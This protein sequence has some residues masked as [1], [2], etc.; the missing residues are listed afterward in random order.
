MIPA[1]VIAAGRS[2]RMGQPKALLTL[3]PDRATFVE[4]L[5]RSL[6]AGGV[7]DVLVVVRPD[8]DALA[9]EIERL[10]ASGCAVRAAANADSDRGQLS[11][12]VV[13]LNAVDRPGVHAIMLAPVDSPLVRSATVRTLIDAFAS[14]PAPIVRATHGGRH[15]HPVI[16]SRVVFDALRH[17]DP[18]IGARAVVRAHAHDAID[19]DV[20]DP[21]VL[22][23]VDNPEDYARLL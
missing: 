19:V 8:D 5:T 22:L 14:R 16:F 10:A 20:D 21:G 1:V 12:V 9:R 2:S 18:S 4:R 3:P 15:G 6:I 17:A 13:G 11:S 7:A 23:D